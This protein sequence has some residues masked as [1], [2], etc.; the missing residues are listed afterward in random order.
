MMYFYI[1]VSIYPSIYLF[2]SRIPSYLFRIRRTEN[3]PLP[4]PR[5]FG[6]EK[7]QSRI[8]LKLQPEILTMSLYEKHTISLH[9]ILNP[10]VESKNVNRR[11]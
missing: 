1:H 7:S 9:A 11:S 4:L 2:S 5:R 3:T 8:R 10:L 6:T